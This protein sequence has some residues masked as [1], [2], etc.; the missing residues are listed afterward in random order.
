MCF[1][2]VAQNEFQSWRVMFL[3]VL[4]Q[5][6][7][8]HTT[9]ADTADGGHARVVPSPDLAAVDD[10][11]ELTLGQEGLDEVH[12]GKVPVVDLPQVEV[13]QD[14]L[15]LLVRVVVLCGAQRVGNTLV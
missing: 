2:L 6:R 14:P 5:S 7:D 10:L 11:G 4:V 3:E 13:L 12:A 9:P 15:V 8:G 1:L